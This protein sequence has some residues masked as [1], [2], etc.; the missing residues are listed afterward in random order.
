MADSSTALSWVHFA[1][2]PPKYHTYIYGFLQGS[3]KI[4]SAFLHAV[5]Q[6]A[7]ALFCCEVLQCWASLGALELVYL[8][9]PNGGEIWV[10]IYWVAPLSGFRGNASHF[11]LQHFIPVHRRT[12]SKEDR[13]LYSLIPKKHHSKC[14]VAEVKCEV[15]LARNTPVFHQPWQNQNQTTRWTGDHTLNKWKHFLFRKCIFRTFVLK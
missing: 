13:K 5:P 9:L 8:F 15:K 10:D 12:A 14:S 7:A 3:C 4:S 2:I 1:W 6:V 11:A